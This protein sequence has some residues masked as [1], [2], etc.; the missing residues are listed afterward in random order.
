MVACFSIAA[1]RLT[2]K[3][4]SVLFAHNEDDGG[5]LVTRLHVVPRIYHRPGEVIKF[6]NTGGSIPQIEG[7]T[8]RYLWSEI[9][10]YFNADAFL[11]EWGVAIAS[12]ACESKETEP[13]DLTNGGI[14]YWISRFVAGRAKTAREG[15]QI[16]AGMVEKLG[17]ASSGRTY[18]VADPKET[19]FCSLVAGRHWVARRVPDDGVAVIPNRYTIRQVE[20]AD[21]QN[22]LGCPD[23]ISYAI[24]RGYY[25]PASGEPFD[26]GKAY[27]SPTSQT[28]ERNA[29]RQWMGLMLL[30]GKGYPFEDLPFSVAPD[31]KLT[32]EDLIGALRSHY[33]TTAYD[34]TTGGDPHR[35]PVRVIC[36]NNTQESFVVQLRSHL[37]SIIGNIYWRA[38]GRP[39]QGV[40]VPW[41]SGTLEIPRPYTIGEPGL[42]DKLPLGERYYDP[43]SAYWVFDRMDALVDEEYEVRSENR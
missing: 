6:W 43:K 10:R 18:I 15:V 20:L 34:Q 35:T 22:F 30:T 2:T 9:P 39:C 14:Y 26:F 27:G 7:E 32:L 36:S 13:Y 24:A 11:N 25:D 33:E 38:L 41:Y 29:C 5:T 28:V 1:G 19:W 17:Y 40:F 37:P 16:I 12:N 42:F 23:L 4:G 8:W 3:D 31:R 21:R